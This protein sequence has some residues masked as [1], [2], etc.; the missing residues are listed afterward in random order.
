MYAYIKGTLEEMT[1]D[2][3]VV[4]TGGI[5]YNVKVST[6]TADLLPGIGSEVKIY[7]YT[8]V[9]EDAF[10]LYGFLTRDDLEVFKKLITVSGIGPKGG[11]AILSVMSADALRF[12]VMAGDAKAI[13]KAPGIGAKTAE[14]V[15]IDLRDKISIEDTLKGLGAPAD[16]AGGNANAQT[17]DNLMKREA[18]EALVALGYSASDATAAVKKVEMKE[19]TTV[20]TI[21]KQA[22]NHMF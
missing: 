16:T 4:E 13:A 14:R 21:L 11:L 7:T 18:I 17:A 10:S 12:A 6:T 9:R 15:I 3:V 8:L 2:S 20:E 22:L 19:D 5:G 1:E